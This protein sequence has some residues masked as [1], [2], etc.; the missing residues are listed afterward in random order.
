M[1]KLFAFIAIATMLFVSCKKQYNSGYADGYAAGSQADYI[2]QQIGIDASYDSQYS[3]YPTRTL[4][5]FEK[6]GGT[7]LS[8]FYLALE[9]EGNS[10]FAPV[11]KNPDYSVSGAWK[12]Y[13]YVVILKYQESYFAPARNTSFYFNYPAFDPFYYGI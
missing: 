3:G 6:S 10:E 11:A 7:P 2:Y 1:K 9:K 13:K 5:V 4:F 12:N 8:R